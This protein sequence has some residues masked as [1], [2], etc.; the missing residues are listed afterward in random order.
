MGKRLGFGH[1]YSLSLGQT[2]KDYTNMSSLA[3]IHFVFI[4][5]VSFFYYRLID[6]RFRHVVCD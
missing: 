4:F 6:K 2:E 1:L 5:C 3:K